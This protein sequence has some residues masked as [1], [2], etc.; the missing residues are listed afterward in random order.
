MYRITATA[1]EKVAFSEQK[2]ALLLIVYTS[3][4]YYIAAMMALLRLNCSQINLG[5]CNSIVLEKE[6]VALADKL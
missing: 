6:T 5:K 4:A 2:S 3:L 1:G